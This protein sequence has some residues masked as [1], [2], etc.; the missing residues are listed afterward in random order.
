MCFDFMPPNERQKSKREKQVSIEPQ[1][2]IAALAGFQ[3]LVFE[4][5]GDPRAIFRD[6]GWAD[7]CLLSP[8]TRISI[9]D[10]RTA[11]NLAGKQTDTTSFGLLLSQRQH[12]EEQGALGYLTKHSATLRAAIEAWM[13]YLKIHQPS[14][15]ARL[16]FDNSI[17]LWEVRLPF[18]PDVSDH[19]HSETS[20]GLVVKFV[21]QNLDPLWNPDAVHF[22]HEAP[23][24]TALHSRIFRCPIFFGAECGCLE[25][26]A[27]DLE[28][29]LRFADPLLHQLLEDYEQS[30][31]A[32]SPRNLR[33]L[34]QSKVSERLEEER[35]TIEAVAAEIGLT[36]SQLQSQLRLEGQTFRQIVDT[37][38]LE[39][40]KKFL[41]DTDMTLTE[42]T[43][44]I[45]Y[46]QSAI[47]TRAFKRLTG[48]TPSTW[49]Q[50][51][52]VK[53]S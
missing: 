31:V 40:A 8:D 34:I 26:P 21:R 15:E 29:P 18:T 37:V 1:I 9:A 22:S 39:R 14:T 28:R 32:Q 6:L 3:D 17:A 2:R 50:Q 16:S 11:L 23:D 52:R 49:K 19:N 44:S 53:A 48:V 7:D 42:I 36:R 47:F 13:S 38:R 51:N 4:L 30:K 33:D 35:I 43:S 25:F 24:D 12:F 27:S 20:A 5:G 41:L 46:A 10:Y 45:G